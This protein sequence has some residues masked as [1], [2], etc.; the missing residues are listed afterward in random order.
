MLCQV[1]PP[2]VPE[3]KTTS[4]VP[5]AGTSS[6]GDKRPGKSGHPRRA[7]SISSS[8]LRTP[9]TD[10]QGHS[11][12]TSPLGG[13]CAARPWRAELTSFC[14]AHAADCAARLRPS[15]RSSG[16]A[17]LRPGPALSLTAR[18][19]G[20]GR[21]TAP[22]SPCPDFPSPGSG[23][24]HDVGSVTD[25]G[26]SASAA[27]GQ[28]CSSASRAAGNN[29]STASRSSLGD[30]RWLTGAA[31]NPA[32]VAAI[33]ATSM[34]S[35]FSPAI[36]TTGTVAAGNADGNGAAA[37]TLGEQAMAGSACCAER[38]HRLHLASW[39]RCR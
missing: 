17:L 6:S 23:G 33:S 5:Q 36:M 15:R 26:C 22:G 4:A 34:S 27:K 13:R 20:S 9:S 25:R 10:S 8:V 30:Q 38:V 37:A 28:Q 18:R 11:V 29:S 16:A 14:T 7:C 1:A 32:S 2:V 19:G 24:G 35:V 31:M 3:V 21:C 39:R 12:V